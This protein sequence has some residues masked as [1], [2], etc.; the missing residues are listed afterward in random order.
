MQPQCWR[1]MPLPAVLSTHRS[2]HVVGR[3]LLAHSLSVAEAVVD[4]TCQ[5]TTTGEW[6]E[7][8]MQ[9]SLPTRGAAGCGG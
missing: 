8:S 4:H 3:Q 2:V 1:S 5:S 7:F 6:L 9:V